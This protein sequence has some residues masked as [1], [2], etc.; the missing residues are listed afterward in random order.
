MSDPVD[1]RTLLK[2]AAA[3]AAGLAAVA[4]F[5][6]EAAEALRFAEPVAFSYEAFKAHAKEMAHGPY[7]GPPRPAPEVIQKIN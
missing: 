5:K 6:A 2:G 1:R 7:V 3:T 4:D